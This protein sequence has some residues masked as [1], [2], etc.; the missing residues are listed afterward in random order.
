MSE[1]PFLSRRAFVRTGLAGA[2]SLLGNV[3]PVRS[4][5][6]KLPQRVLG[7]TGVRVP[8]LGLGT[9]AVGNVSDRKKAVALL[10]RAINLGVTY[11]DTAPPRT[12]IA[13]FTGYGKA[14]AYLNGVLKE[15]RKEVFVATKC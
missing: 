5:E 4:A 2:A 13:L 15:R 7:K 12:R 14:Q 1:T 3:L 11:L 9:V 6:A 8:I 10:N